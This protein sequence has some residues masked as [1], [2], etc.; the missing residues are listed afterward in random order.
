M[1]KIKRL[2]LCLFSVLMLE[3]VVADV[4]IGVVPDSR[5]IIVPGVDI[6]RQTVT[7]FT[8]EADQPY[9]IELSDSNNGVMVNA[10]HSIAYRV[11]Y[12]N[13]AE[14]R[15]TAN[16]KI[17]ESGSVVSSVSREIAVTIL[18]VD[19]ATAA[20]GDYSATLTIT[21]TGY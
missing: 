11:S 20:A 19:T 4:N 17:V 14:I 13:N 3:Q 7:L 18:G 1:W 10:Y 12:N 8:V 21:I 9:T 15:M 5:I 2:F 16:P 6:I